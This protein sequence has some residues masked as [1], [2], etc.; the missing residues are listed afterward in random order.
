MANTVSLNID[1]QNAAFE[2]PSE[3]PNILRALADKLEFGPNPSRSIPIRD[4]NG[5]RVGEL[6]IE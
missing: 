5:N 3:L 4:S 2:D 1:C 6:E